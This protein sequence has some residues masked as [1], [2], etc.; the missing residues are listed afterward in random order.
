MVERAVVCIKAEEERA[1]GPS[2]FARVP[3]IPADDDIHCAQVF[4]LH[5]AA[6]A[7]LVATIEALADD[8]IETCPLEAFEPILRDLG[9]SRCRG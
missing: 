6:H 4:D 8:A 9:V 2:L 1:D 3:A 5:H 7:R